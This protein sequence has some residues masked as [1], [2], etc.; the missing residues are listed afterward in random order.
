[1]KQM[2]AFI[3]A[4]MSE[5]LGYGDCTTIMSVMVTVQIQERAGNVLPKQLFDFGS[6]LSEIRKW[7]DGRN[8]PITI[9]DGFQGQLVNTLPYTSNPLLLLKIF[10]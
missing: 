7:R 3:L 6:G 8:P 10:N 1:M 2:V 4:V 9:Y 5:K